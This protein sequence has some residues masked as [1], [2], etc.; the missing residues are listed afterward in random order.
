[1][2]AVKPNCRQTQLCCS[3]NICNNWIWLYVWRKNV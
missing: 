3:S 1:M 2:Y